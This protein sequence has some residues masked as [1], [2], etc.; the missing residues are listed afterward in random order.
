[1][2]FLLINA[3]KKNSFEHNLH[4]STMKTPSAFEVC[5]KD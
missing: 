2:L 4:D 3:W 1:V 5:S